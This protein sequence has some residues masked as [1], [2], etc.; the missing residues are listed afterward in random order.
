[1]KI[2][3]KIESQLENLW[4]KIGLEGNE[5]ELQYE[6][7]NRRVQELCKNYLQENFDRVQELTQEAE[8]AENA[9]RLHIKRFNLEDNDDFID[10]NL[11]L[12]YRI[13]N[14]RDKLEMLREDT[15]EQEEAYLQKYNSIKK[16]FE[17]LEMG[18][19]EQGEY[20][21]EG[22]DFSLDKIDRMSEFLID[23]EN[24]ID[25]RQP[26]MDELCDEL[27]E[28]HEDLQI[29]EF[30]RPETLGNP[31]FV[32]LQKER[33]T[34]LEHL[35][36][37]RE[38]AVEL[39]RSI[40]SIERVLKIKLTTVNAAASSNS[41]IQ[42]ENPNSNLQVC[43]DEVIEQLT[44]RLQQLEKEKEKRIPEFVEASKNK[45]L[46]L[47]GELHIPLPSASDFPFIH[48]QAPPNKRTLVA[49][50]SEL[51]RIEN[52][53]AHI[54]PMLDLIAAREEIMGHYNKMMSHG[55]IET[56]RNLTSRRGSV[57]SALL[58]EERIRKKYQNELPKIHSKLIPMLQEYQQ[59][60]GEPFLWDGE[61]LLQEV[62]E[63]HKKEEAAKP[64][65]NESTIMS[66]KKTSMTKAKRK[67]LLSQRAPFQ[68]QEFMF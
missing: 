59:T 62:M 32:R 43:G 38:E 20:A 36:S 14:A 9:V 48:P 28:I 56:S 67:K 55:N 54:E 50:E 68:L 23:L 37:N 24:E 17:I 15:Q 26:K 61:D 42:S 53:K 39:L 27:T 19:D 16:C 1:M 5:I 52:L 8:D 65:R 35:D 63:L 25:E 21:E 51:R 2:E 6:D 49:I 29:E 33:D 47:W 22:D 66:E 4:H 58:E 60:F 30:V 11:P 13:Q 7:L 40:H 57:A 44:E 10:E 31:T 12:L 64:K 34:L 41:G 18:P 46:E 45:L 3:I